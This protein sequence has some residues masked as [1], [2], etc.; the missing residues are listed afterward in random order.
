MMVET[1]PPP[2]VSLIKCEFEHL[3]EENPNW[4]KFNTEIIDLGLLTFSVK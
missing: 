2:E 1:P 3:T 4:R